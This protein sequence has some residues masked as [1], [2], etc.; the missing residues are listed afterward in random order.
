MQALKVFGKWAPIVVM[1]L[2]IACQASAP[3]TSLLEGSDFRG[4]RFRCNDS[5]GVSICLRVLRDGCSLSITPGEGLPREPQDK[6]VLSNG[7]KSQVVAGPSDLVGCVNIQNEQD[8]LE[9]LRF[10]SSYETVHLFK[11]QEL[12]IYKEKCFA[13]CLAADRWQALGLGQVTAVSTE[14]AF[15]VTRYVIKPAANIPEVQIYRVA[16]RVN[17]E[18][19]VVVVESEPVPMSMEDRLR[20]SFPLFL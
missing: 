1:F 4:Q 3:L 8:S 13:V 18:G 20:L 9:Y 10:F 16:Q 5:K 19:D 17:R 6:L 7:V 11:E 12:E 14:D 2:G 15:E